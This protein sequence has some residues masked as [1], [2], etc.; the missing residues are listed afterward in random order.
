MSEACWYRRLRSFSRAL[1]MTS[2]SFVGTSGFIRTGDTS[3]RS[4][5]ALKIS[6]E[7]SPR[8][9]SVPVHIS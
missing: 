1:W 5:M 4:R 6:A 2:S 9:G 3:G 8:N 7:V